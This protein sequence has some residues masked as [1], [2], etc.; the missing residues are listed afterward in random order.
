MSHKKVIIAILSLFLFVACDG[1]DSGKRVPIHQDDKKSGSGSGGQGKGVSTKTLSTKEDDG[2]NCLDIYDLINTQIK[3]L[4]NAR[5]RAYTSDLRVLKNL[6]ELD[7]GNIETIEKIDWAQNNYVLELFR[8]KPEAFLY[9]GQ[10]KD[11][12]D[13]VPSDLAPFK[14]YK[15]VQKG[16]QIIEARLDNSLTKQAYKI[17]S[18]NSNDFQLAIVEPNNSAMYV[19]TTYGTKKSKNRLV[20]QKYTLNQERTDCDKEDSEE[21][22]LTRQVIVYEWNYRRNKKLEMTTVLANSFKEIIEGVEKDKKKSQNNKG[23]SKLP[24]D[25]SDTLSKTDKSDT[26]RVNIYK[27][28][29]ESIL[30]VLSKPK[31]TAKCRK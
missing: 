8:E 23:K 16:C 4:D 30:R 27:D 15:G 2:K 11:I 5:F 9:V 20:F 25:F 18:E 29:Y 31:F 3:K 1:K 28:D 26:G 10:A 14:F 7:P 17:D 21:A 13:E 22:I 24:P 12:G 19:F 6:D